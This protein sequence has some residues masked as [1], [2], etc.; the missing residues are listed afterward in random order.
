MTA[1]FLHVVFTQL[2]F[3]II[4]L[5]QSLQGG[6]LRLITNTTTSLPHTAVWVCTAANSTEQGLLCTL[7]QVTLIKKKKS[8][9]RVEISIVEFLMTY[10]EILHQLY[11]FGELPV[12]DLCC[13]FSGIWG[14]LK[15]N[16]NEF[17]V[18]IKLLTCKLL[19]KSV[20]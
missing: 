5:N 13:L 8:D 2:L 12:V 3:G 19:P 9:F 16:L 18:I 4:D 1:S 14:F 17:F 11:F 6:V 20:F 10:L 15:I 7:Q